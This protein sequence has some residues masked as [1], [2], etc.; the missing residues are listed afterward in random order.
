MKNKFTEFL[1]WSP[2]GH[3]DMGLWFVVFGGGAV[4]AGLLVAWLILR[5]PAAPPAAA[6]AGRE[7]ALPGRGKAARQRPR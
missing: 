5:R 2:R 3:E 4:L 1:H 7:R 6:E